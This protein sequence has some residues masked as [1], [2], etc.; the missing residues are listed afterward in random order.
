MRRVTRTVTPA[1]PPAD[2]FLTPAEAARVLKVSVD[3]LLKLDVPTVRVGGGRKRPHYRYLE[4]A[5]FE[6]GRRRQ[7]PRPA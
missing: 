5:L 3:T 4:S 2:R 1:P 7:E 6:W